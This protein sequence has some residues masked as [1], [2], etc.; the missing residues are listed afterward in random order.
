MKKI[1]LGTII[2]LQSFFCYSQIDN[3]PGGKGLALNFDGVDDYMEFNFMN[4][5]SKS[6]FTFEMWVKIPDDSNIEK[7]NLFSLYNCA[8]GFN[9]YLNEYGFP[10]FQWSAGP[11]NSRG[12]NDII[13]SSFVNIKDNKWHHLAFIRNKDLNKLLISIDGSQKGTIPSKSAGYDISLKDVKLIFGEE[14]ENSSF[15]RSFLGSIDELFFWKRPLSEEE[16]TNRGSCISILQMERLDEFH[17]NQGIASGDNTAFTSAYG[18]AEN[19][20][21]LKNFNLQGNT[22]NFVTSDITCVISENTQVI[23]YGA[24]NFDGNDD[25][26]ELYSSSEQLLGTASTVDVWVKIPKPDTS[27]LK[28]GEIVGAI[29]GNYP[30]VSYS[31]NELGQPKIYWNHGEI[32]F[33][34][35]KDL[36]DNQWHHLA[37][38]RNIPDNKFI[39]YIDGSEDASYNSAGNN[40]LS[41]K[42][43]L[44]GGD[45]ENNEVNSFHGTI[46]DIRL[47]PEYLTKEEI[48]ISKNSNFETKMSFRPS[49]TWTF[50]IGESNVTDIISSFRSE[51][52][53]N[54]AM[55]NFNR[56]GSTSN[57]VIGHN[58]A[59]SITDYD[60]IQQR[61]IDGKTPNQVAQMLVNINYLYG[62]EY[63]GELIFHY[64][65][66]DHSIL[67]ASKN[68]IGNFHWGT[69]VTDPNNPNINTDVHNAMA[70]SVS[71]GKGYSNTKSIIKIGSNSTTSSSYASQAAYKAYKHSITGKAYY[72]P[73]SKEIQLI[74]KNLRNND[75]NK[76]NNYNR[77]YW[78]S[79]SNT[80]NNA[81]TYN[82]LQGTASNL[83]KS[84]DAFVLPIRTLNENT[85]AAKKS[86][87]KLNI[88][89]GGIFQKISNS[90]WVRTFSGRTNVFKEISLS[91]TNLILAPIIPSTVNIGSRLDFDLVNMIVKNYGQ[92]A[93][94]TQ[95]ATSETIYTITSVEK[96]VPDKLLEE[97]I[98]FSTPGTFERFIS[99]SNDVVLKE[100]AQRSIYVVEPKIKNYLAYL[101]RFPKG[102]WS[103]EG[104]KCNKSVDRTI[105]DL[106]WDIAVMKNTPQSYQ[107]YLD[108]DKTKNPIQYPLH[109]QD[110][111]TFL[112]DYEYIVVVKMLKIKCTKSYDNITS[113]VID[114]VWKFSLVD[115]EVKVIHNTYDVERISSNNYVAPPSFQIEEGDP[116][117]TDIYKGTIWDV[118]EITNNDFFQIYFDLYE[119]NGREVTGNLHTDDIENVKKRINIDELPTN[120]PKEFPLK[121][122]SDDNEVYVTFEVTKMTKEAWAEHIRV[123]IEKC[124]EKVAKTYTSPTLRKPGFL[125]RNET[126]FDLDIS[127]NQVGP[128]YYGVVKPGETFIRDTGA[129][130]FTIEASVNI[131]GVPKYDD[132]DCVAPAVKFTADVLS[133]VFAGGAAL[134]ARG[135]VAAAY[136]SASRLSQVATGAEKV[137]VAVET[138]NKYNGYRNKIN[139]VVEVATLVTTEFAEQYTYTSEAGCYAGWSGDVKVYTITGGP[140]IP[141][142]GSDGSVVIEKSQPLKINVPN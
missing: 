72:L 64:D 127:L 7:M 17:F 20:A 44:I 94:T 92:N 37:F 119:E 118:F 65:I 135:G 18:N 36:R 77:T 121:M 131:D 128:L 137:W 40:I 90:E 4:S 100:Y 13:A 76:L 25:Y 34:G 138:F 28:S 133:A 142:M 31:I 19:T 107:E 27:G 50:N 109:E 43:L 66:N 56:Y 47:W 140:Q 10:E 58:H 3:I 54:Y 14:L 38:V 32:N 41:N 23:D 89:Q 136:A 117:K 60:F 85:T 62:K 30:Y 80:E 129:V 96:S 141:C 16:I 86:I 8:N 124:E 15:G 82:I 108:L 87:F 46:D 83:S 75:P 79:S 101:S 45:Y 63:E 42:K 53:H 112:K 123:S 126:D 98:E 114:L 73:S 74:Y 21:P 104:C 33:A 59:T 115:K 130:W 9:I 125:I 11:N 132:W 6:S 22:S 39:I 113:D 120:H 2:M 105:D 61:I 5:I 57:F 12:S 110:A 35:N 139:T 67:L 99:Q 49:N 1:I 88:Y 95:M 84:Q 48:D 102:F 78:T 29:L 134:A 93:T 81:I 24:I 51:G 70:T 97:A 106:H 26:V 111:E 68:D 71:I 116:E 69:L 122:A 52:G 103:Q 91:T 55:Y